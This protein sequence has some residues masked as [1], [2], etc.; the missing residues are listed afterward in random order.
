MPLKFY[1][2][3][4]TKGCPGSISDFAGRQPDA[5]LYLLTGET[6]PVAPEAAQLLENQEV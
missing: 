5:S 3:S 1:V 2:A 4:Q 6:V